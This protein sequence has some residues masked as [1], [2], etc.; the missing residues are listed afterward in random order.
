[1]KVGHFADAKILVV[2]DLES[3]TFFLE[4]ILKNAGYKNIERVHDARQVVAVFTMF[5]PDVV[6]LDLRMP[7]MDGLEVMERL[8]PTMSDE[9]PVP[10]IMLTADTDPKKKNRAF[11]LGVRDFIHK[12]FDLTEVRYRIKNQLET[13]ALHLMMSDQN[14]ALEKQVQDRTR[15]LQDARLEI[16]TRLAIAAEYREDA[17]GKHAARVG[18]LAGSIAQA[19]E[20]PDEDVELVARAAPLHDVGKIGVPDSI[21]TQEGQLT[22][23]QF[24]IVKRHTDIG[25]RILGRGRSKLLQ[26]AEEIALTHH[27]S[28][29]GRGYAGMVGDE[30]PLNGRIVA[31]ADAFNAMT[32]DRPYRDAVSLDAA[33]DEVTRLSGRTFDPEV[34]R[35]FRRV[36]ASDRLVEILDT[37]DVIDLT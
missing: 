24:R 19:M 14:T 16:V 20:L 22:D 13:R 18:A 5:Q 17:T 33:V 10:I 28:W 6:L 8:M 35:A 21:L 2:D 36:H 29:D 1:M 27:E 12:P 9:V 15:E 37:P 4:R 11:E 7:H 3:N 26:V 23:A 25:A 32:T 34:V 30:I 31:V